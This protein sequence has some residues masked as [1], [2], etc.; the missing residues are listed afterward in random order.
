MLDHLKR[1]YTK[2][3][4]EGV[5]S[6]F[7]RLS[8]PLPKT[9]EFFETREGGA[10]VLVTDFGCTVR[11]TPK[12]FYPDIRHPRVLQPL[13]SRY[14]ESFHMAVNPGLRNLTGV[15]DQEEMEATLH[16][17]GGIDCGDLY[18]FN[19]CTLPSP[20]ESYKIVIDPDC[21]RKINKNTRHVKACLDG[22]DPQSRIFSSLRQRFKEGYG[23]PSKMRETWATCIQEKRGKNLSSSWEWMNYSKKQISMFDV[24]KIGTT[25]AAE[26]YAERLKRE[27]RLAYD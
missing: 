18:K 4:V 16:R 19:I 11:I 25:Q 21:I 9:G 1:P 3:S 24:W 26:N 2:P 7:E 17:E 8:L 27:I 14:S 23:D 6:F 12:K 15:Y 22:D 5:A 10:L 13:I 20:H